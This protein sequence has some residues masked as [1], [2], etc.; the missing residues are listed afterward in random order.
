MH[1]TVCH[2]EFQVRDL[3]KAQAFYAGLFGWRFSSF[4]P[5]MVV[6]GVGDSHIGGLMQSDSP[7]TG[8]SPSVWFRVQ[9]LDLM[10]MKATEVGGSLVEAK[11]EVPSVGW[12]AVVADP[13]GNRVG[14]VMYT[15]D[16]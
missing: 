15:E 7:E 8:A 16:A 9:D 13:D 5:G 3:D 2:I 10:A 12:S 4:F 11:S 6:F 14:L 1:N